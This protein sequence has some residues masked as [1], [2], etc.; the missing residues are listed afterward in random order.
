MHVQGERPAVLSQTSPFAAFSDSVE[1]LVLDF[2]KLPAGNA[3][4]TS[5]LMLPRVAS[6]AA[7]NEILTCSG[8]LQ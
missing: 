5:L 6:D 1:C 4:V 7:L 2:T 3:A 8:A